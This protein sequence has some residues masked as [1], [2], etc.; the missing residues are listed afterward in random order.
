MQKLATLQKQEEETELGWK[1]E[2]VLET[3]QNSSTAQEEEAN[4]TSEI[5]KASCKG[6]KKNENIIVRNVKM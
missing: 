5:S 1:L 2:A 6:T 3:K 4:V